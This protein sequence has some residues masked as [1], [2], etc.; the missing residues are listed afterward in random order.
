[1]TTTVIETAWAA[2]PSWCTY[3]HASDTSEAPGYPRCHFA[4]ETTVG[5]AEVQLESTD[6][7]PAVIWL[8]LEEDARLTAKE[9]RELA[10]TLEATADELDL[11][12]LAHIATPDDMTVTE[13]L[14]IAEREEV[15]AHVLAMKYEREK[16]VRV[17]EN[18]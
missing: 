9:A 8:A 6:A 4:P 11:G 18:D 2:C 7:T 13:W 12:R 16:G 15:P 1:M 5:P 17:D 10:R 14:A 3:D